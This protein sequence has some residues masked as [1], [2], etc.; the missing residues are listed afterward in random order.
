MAAIISEGMIRDPIDY[1]DMIIAAGEWYKVL[2][3]EDIF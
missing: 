1:P 3:P 2:P